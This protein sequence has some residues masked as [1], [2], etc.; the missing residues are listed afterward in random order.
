M[1]TTAWCTILAGEKKKEHGYAN[2]CC[3][4]SLQWNIEKKERTALVSELYNTCVE[5]WYSITDKKLMR[6][7]LITK[8]KELRH[9]LPVNVS[10]LKKLEVACRPMG[11]GMP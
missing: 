7:W 6:R 9:F 3:S 1:D 2:S 8:V 4:R 10:K 5:Q 11:D